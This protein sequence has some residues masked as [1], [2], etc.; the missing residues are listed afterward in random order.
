MRLSVGAVDVHTGNF[1]YFDNTTQRI[2]PKHV[3]ASGSLPPGFPRR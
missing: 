1:I 2:G 3:I